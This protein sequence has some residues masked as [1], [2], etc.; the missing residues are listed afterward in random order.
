MID[1]VSSLLPRLQQFS[2]SLN[3]TAIF[4]D[5]PWG[6]VDDDG[7]KV[8][9]IFRRNNELLVS[10][11]GEVTTG[12]W[13]YLPA[14]QSLLITHDGRKRMFNQGFVDNVVMALRKD[15]TEELFLL[16][17]QQVIPDMNAVRYLEQKVNNPH[18]P[19][20]STPENKLVKVELA[21]PNRFIYVYQG[22]YTVN[23]RVFSTI[24]ENPLPDGIYK[25]KSRFKIEVENG[26]IKKV[27]IPDEPI[28]VSP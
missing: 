20:L 19:K 5:I 23:N 7:N 4:A 8:T 11:K 9:Y 16:A 1:Y 14:L 15:G 12:H 13:E 28:I 21:H 17:N 26:L 24:T 6:F 3:D 27:T 25:T 18:Q 2:K 10:M 22:M